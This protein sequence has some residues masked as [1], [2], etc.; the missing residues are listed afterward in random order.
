MGHLYYVWGDMIARKM[1]FSVN[2]QNMWVHK[3]G[4]YVGSPGCPC[5][6]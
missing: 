6:Q 1:D 2:H 3:F 4:G 5:L